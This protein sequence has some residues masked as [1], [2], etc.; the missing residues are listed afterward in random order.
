MPGALTWDP[1][2]AGGAQSTARGGINPA[3]DGANAAL[4]ALAAR[5]IDYSAYQ[6][7]NPSSASNVATLSAAIDAALL[8]PA[9]HLVLPA[10][11]FYMPSVLTKSIGSKG[12]RVTG[13]GGDRTQLLTA[14]SSYVM[15][16]L[17]PAYG[18]TVA[19]TVSAAAGDTSVTVADSSIFTAGKWAN[20][21]SAKIWDATSG[22]NAV[23]GE[24][25]RVKSIAGGVITL[26][27]PLK[28]A[29]ST[30]D[31][32]LMLPCDLAGGFRMEGVGFINTAPLTAASGV[33][34]GIVLRRMADIRLDDIYG[35]AL[36][37]P[38][39]TYEAIVG[40]D[41]RG[42]CA[43]YLADDE[44][45]G[46][47]GYVHNIGNAT[48]GLRI[49]GG[50]TFACRHHVTT[51]SNPAITAGGVPVN[52]TIVGAIAQAYTNVAFDTHE[53]GDATTF[54]GCQAIDC[55]DTGFGLRAPRSVLNG[56]VVV[57]GKGPGIN[58]R[59]SALRSAVY[60]ASVSDLTGVQSARSNPAVG[61]DISAPEALV[62]GFHINNVGQSG[63][64]ILG[65]NRVTIRNGRIIGAGGSG[66]S[67]WGVHFSGPSLDHEIQDVRIDGAG[68]A[69]SYGLLAGT[70]G[71]AVT[72]VKVSNVTTR[73]VSGAHQNIP[74]VTL[75][76]VNG[77]AVTETVINS[78][79]V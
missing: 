52:N 77:S 41:V 62:D 34:G 50:Y 70:A 71:N 38:L 55:M 61:I 54:T 67:P 14:N 10:G 29:Y 28:Y 22:K 33:A 32:P 64:R 23:Y 56:P 30:S 2:P 26:Y 79:L 48:T 1:T 9:P 44:T 47:Y 42:V 20:I 60:G 31:T 6:P 13:Q 17:G 19:V 78:T 46:R 39:L 58:I 36:D 40:G 12:L 65:A 53:E 51:N 25:V 24:M 76:T 59:A 11:V 4:A 45:N 43:K 75:N 7:S 3:A 57:N 66:T 21:K 69:T 18:S 8:L 49:A 68:Y 15:D 37:G 72:G 63:I 16:L 73:R 74:N 35:E 27:A 5:Y